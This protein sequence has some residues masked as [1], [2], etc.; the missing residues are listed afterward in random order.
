[1]SIN[2]IRNKYDKTIAKLQVKTNKAS[3]DIELRGFI[4][5]LGGVSSSGKTFFIETLYNQ[6]L[7]NSQEL[8]SQ[9]GLQGIQ[10]LNTLTLNDGVEDKEMIGILK[11]RKGFLIVIDNADT[12]LE[13]REALVQHIS[14]DTSNQYI[15]MSR[16]GV[17]LKISSNH[18]SELE[19]TDGKIVNKF[20]TTIPG[21]K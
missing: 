4:T 2:I 20:L 9:Y 10:I 16:G 7:N 18:Y 17:N 1:M 21:W 11:S 19:N 5:V 14:R 15:I 8:K 12:I 3:F 13:N 6:Y